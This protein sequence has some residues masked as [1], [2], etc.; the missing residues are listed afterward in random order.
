MPASR[1]V[2]SFRPVRGTFPTILLR[3][4]DREEPLYGSKELQMG[5]L[6]AGRHFFRGDD[7]YE[8]ARRGT[9]WNRRVPERYP[10]LIVQAVDADDVVAA[11][12]T[13]KP[14]AIESASVRAGTAGPQTTSAT[15]PCWSTSAA[16]T[17]PPSTPTAGSPWSDRARAAVCCPPTST[18]RDCSS[19]PGTAKACAS[20]GTCCRVV[21]AGTAASSALPA[22]A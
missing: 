3:I 9:V 20:A 10:D 11:I 5:G 17:T 14:A 6:P 16:S 7:G 12:G 21:M 19:P 13:Q 8:P 4:A 1:F 22:K 15:A 18:L 2:G